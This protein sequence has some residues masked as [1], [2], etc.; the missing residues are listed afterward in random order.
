MKKNE[1]LSKFIVSQ[2]DVKKLEE[3]I[4]VFLELIETAQL[5]LDD[6]GYSI[7]ITPNYEMKIAGL[8]NTKPTS[9]KLEAFVIHKYDSLSKLQDLLL[10]Y[11]KAFNMLSEKEKLIFKKLYID[12][13][14]KSVIQ[15]ELMMY[16]YQ[17][18][19]IKKSM[20]V[21]FSI[22]LGLDKYIDIF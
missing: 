2:Y 7:K 1:L 21:K 18:D 6:E 9:S 20:V 17:F 15:E 14:K 13:E 16:Q 3:I 8:G 12:A 22:V 5:I 4:K 19:A 10:K 11:P